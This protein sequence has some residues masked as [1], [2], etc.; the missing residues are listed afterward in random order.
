[1]QV[2]NNKSNWFYWY[3]WRSQVLVVVKYEYMY[4]KTAEK[5]LCNSELNLINKHFVKIG[6]LFTILSAQ[7]NCM[8]VQ[9]QISYIKWII[10][11]LLILTVNKNLLICDMSI[12]TFKNDAFNIL[13]FSFLCEMITVE[14]L[15]PLL[16]C[17]MST[18]NSVCWSR[19]VC[20]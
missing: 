1:M 19:L 11:L 7:K 9:L 4:N 14:R 8:K 3:W 18:I 20:L 12:N 17:H 2:N 10:I 5:K 16:C 6:S 15:W 13:R